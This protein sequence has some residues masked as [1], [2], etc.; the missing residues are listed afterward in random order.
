MTRN[1]V[2]NNFSE[3]YSFFIE[4]ISARTEVR[5][6]FQYFV[7]KVQLVQSKCF[8]YRFYVIYWLWWRQNF[9]VFKYVKKKIN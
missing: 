2:W 3:H 9:K 6:V 1:F 4:Y 7:M 5:S 8:F